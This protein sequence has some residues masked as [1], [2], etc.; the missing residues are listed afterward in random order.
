VRAAQ[1]AATGQH[2][3]RSARLASSIVRDAEVPSG[4]LVLDIGAGFG[5]LTGPLLDGGARVVALE[6]NTQR[7]RADDR[8]E[9]G[10]P[11]RL[12][13]HPEHCLVLR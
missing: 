7:A 4:A 5:R 3:L 9:A 10:H 11:L 8:W 13:W 6:Q 12:G 1:A 2:F